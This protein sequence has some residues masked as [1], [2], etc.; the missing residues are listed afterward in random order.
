MSEYTIEISYSL[1]YRRWI[2]MVNGP[3]I[4]PN[5]DIGMA[6][7]HWGARRMAIKYLKDMSPRIKS[8]EEDLSNVITKIHDIRSYKDIISKNLMEQFGVSME[9]AADCADKLVSVIVNELVFDPLLT[10]TD[11]L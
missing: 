6:I 1:K 7:T 5:C 4:P 10:G 2:P 3:H 9:T 8:D 11:K